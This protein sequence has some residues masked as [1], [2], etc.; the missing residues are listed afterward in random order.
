MKKL[1]TIIILLVIA[2]PPLVVG[3]QSRVEGRLTDQRSGEPVAFANCVLLSPADSHFVAGTA[4]DYNGRFAIDNV[5]PGQWL[6]RLSAVGYTTVYHSFVAP[7]TQ[8]LKFELE[9]SATLLR[10]F[11]ITET[12]PIYSADG[13]K[14]F[15]HVSDDPSVQTGSA[16]D[17]LQNAP[18]VEVDAEGNIRYRG[19]SN[20]QVW[21]NGHPSRLDGE[22]LKQYIK[23]LPA[24]AIKRIEVISN[25]SARYSSG[26]PIVNIVT[27]DRIERNELLCLGGN[28][29]TTP[30]AQPWLSYVYANDRLSLNLWANASVGSFTI[31]S[32]NHDVF[33]ANDGTL[34]SKLDYNGTDRQSHRS[35]GFGGSFNITIDSATTLAVWVGGY[36]T[37]QPQSS[38]HDVERYEYIY[39]SG[40]YSYRSN[41]GVDNF[42]ASAWGGAWLEHRIDTLGQKLE[43][44]LNSNIYFSRRNS[45][46]ERQYVAMPQLDVLHNVASTSSNWWTNLDA[47]YTKPFG[48]HTLLQVGG[49]LV[50]G[51]GVDH[52]LW[53]TLDH[54]L[55]SMRRD[56]DRT[57][58]FFVNDG[59]ANAYI[60]LQHTLGRFTAKGGARLYRKWKVATY[61]DLP[62]KTKDYDVFRPLWDFI[63]SLHLSYALE[64]GH[65]FTLSYTR[66]FSSPAANNYSSFIILSDDSYSVGNPDLRLSHTHNFEGGWA[67]YRPWGSL[68]LNGYLNANTDEIGTLSDVAFSPYFGR[69]VSFTQTTNIG[70]SRTAGAQANLAY[71]PKPFVSLRLDLGAYNYGYSYQLRPDQWQ[72]T[73]MTTF[74]ARLNLWAKLWNLLQVYANAY[75]TSPSL[76]LMAVSG[77]STG[78]DVGIS[79]DLMDRRLSLYLNVHDLF[80]TNGETTEYLNPYYR[81]NYGYRYN[82]RFV[83]LGLAWR[84]GRLELESRARQGVDS[85]LK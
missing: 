48:S 14:V 25:P 56:A 37:W 13:E 52:T 68:S 64:N 5:E 32:E 70:N 79:A 59:E 62:F 33:F 4:T 15:Y 73:A 12:R 19:S 72:D 74:T 51:H 84:L 66:R 10:E 42:A 58:S 85:V 7:T 81:A 82:S 21:L 27:T 24:S 35:G 46:T 18:G 16:S 55:D 83:S 17:A 60:T 80:H 71:R 77:P 78:V 31:E 57:Y 49:S 6:L 20:L 1:K 47:D 63:P 38:S 11:S 53:D 22:A 2:M 45:S 69:I 23:L 3:A 65:S 44:T 30:V 39:A 28:L 36:P 29:T 76:Q 54:A 67:L 50:Y 61:A 43:L 40:N 26:S 41:Y 75:Y 34:S 8:P 9:S